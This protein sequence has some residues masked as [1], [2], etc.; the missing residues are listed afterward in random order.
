MP[1]SFARAIT[2]FVQQNA[3]RVQLLSTQ[4]NEFLLVVKHDSGSSV[5]PTYSYDVA[6]M[7]GLVA[8]GL[9]GSERFNVKTMTLSL[10]GIELNSSGV[11]VFKINHWSMLS[12]FLVNSSI[13]NMK[14][15]VRESS[16][17][18]ILREKYNCMTIIM[19]KSVCSSNLMK[20]NC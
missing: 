1:I 11:L 12:Q 19:I 8:A 17:V 18:F 16:D 6:K 3:T 15:L 4:A 14:F 7:P 2:E 20:N 5:G 10:A 13:T 9:V